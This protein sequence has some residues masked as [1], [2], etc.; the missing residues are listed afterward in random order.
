MLFNT[1]KE[2]RSVPEIFPEGAE[3]EYDRETNTWI[4]IDTGKRSTVR[5]SLQPDG[6]YSLNG[7]SVD[8][9]E[10]KAVLRE[11]ESEN[12]L[13]R[14][15]LNNSTYS[16]FWDIVDFYHPVLKKLNLS[17]EVKAADT[18]IELICPLFTAGE[19]SGD[20][21]TEF[22]ISFGNSYENGVDLCISILECLCDKYTGAERKKLIE[23]IPRDSDFAFFADRY[24]LSRVLSDKINE[25]MN[26]E[27][28]ITDNMGTM[29]VM[30][31]NGSSLEYRPP[32]VE[33][34][35]P[36]FIVMSNYSQMKRVEDNDDYSLVMRI[37]S[38]TD[39]IVPVKKTNG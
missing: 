29:C 32:C 7:S 11:R 35:T 17:S 27:A 23:I 22:Y 3:Y 14:P 13:L 12:S 36:G 18:G 16:V 39:L 24:L 1:K 38:L 15:F 28:Q 31:K 4:Y 20:E 21:G 8:E 26:T 2:K 9:D 25:L 19:K 34:E 6:T 33:T 10:V 30:F 5:I 37:L